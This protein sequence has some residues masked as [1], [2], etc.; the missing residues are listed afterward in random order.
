MT[1]TENKLIDAIAEL[2]NG[3]QP[4]WAGLELPP[5]IREEIHRRTR[6]RREATTGA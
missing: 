4:D 3:F 2:M 5:D 1:D 6:D